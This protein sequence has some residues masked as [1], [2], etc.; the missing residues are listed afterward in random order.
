MSIELTLIATRLKCLFL[1]SRL[2]SSDYSI[3]CA[4]CGDNII[5]INQSSLCES[6]DFHKRNDW[7]PNIT[8]RLKCLHRLPVICGRRSKY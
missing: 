8:V 5:Y 6:T 4:V 2:V 7:Q 3:N 1:K